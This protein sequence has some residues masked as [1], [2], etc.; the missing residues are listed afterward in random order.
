MCDSVMHSIMAAVYEKGERPL[1]S[2]ADVQVTR[3]V[4]ALAAVTAAVKA[5]LR[6]YR[7]FECRWVILRGAHHGVV[8]GVHEEGG[9]VAVHVAGGDHSV[10]GAL[11]L[12]VA[13]QL[14]HVPQIDG[15][16]V[17]FRRHFQ[18]LACPRKRSVISKRV[19]TLQSRSGGRAKVWV[20]TVPTCGKRMSAVGQQ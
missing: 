14:E 18:P 7:E 1:V 11:E 15:E 12:P 5:V 3:C 9:A 10:E 4:R 13:P 16:V 8:G 19:F 17:L 2:D 20:L 6:N